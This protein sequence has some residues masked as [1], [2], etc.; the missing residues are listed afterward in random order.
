MTSD[1]NAILAAMRCISEGK[2]D[3]AR[4]LCRQVLEKNPLSAPG[5]HTLGLVAYMAR[6]Y[7]TAIEHITRAT[8]IDG[9][10]PQY[11]SNLG[12][13][14]R[15]AGRSKDALETFDK[16]L[17]AMPEFLK[18]HLGAGNALRDLGRHQEA[19]AK[20]RLALAIDPGFAEAYHYLGLALAEQERFEEALP[21][22]RKAVAIRPGYG[23]AQLTL[24]NTL[25]RTGHTEEALG[26]YRQILERDPGN[27]AVHNNIGNLLKS[28][29]RIEE[30]I[31]HY[32]QALELDPD[33]APAYYNL[34][35][36]QVGSAEEELSRMEA[37]LEDRHLA[38]ER[39]VNLHFALGKILDDL[40]RY[41]EAFPHFRTGNELDGRGRPFNA[42][43]HGLAINR[44]IGVFSRRFITARRGFGS[45]SE[46]P[47]LI[48]GM[49]RSGTSL[50]EQILASHPRVFGAGELD[51]IGRIVAALPKALG[52]LAGYPDCATLLDAAAACRFGEE[53]VSRLRVVGGDA[54]RV[55]DKM[56]GNFLNLGFVALLLPNARIIHCRRQ[57]LDVCLSCYFQ[58]FTSVM[59][60]TWNLS[61]LGRYYRDYERLMAHWRKV[62]PLSMLE[63]DYEE[64]IDNQE[65]TSRRIVD[66]VGLEWDDACLEFHKTDRPVKTASSWQVRQ[67]IY[68]SSVARWRNYEHFLGPLREAL[69][70]VLSESGSEAEAEEG[71][72][73]APARKRPTARKK[74]A[75]RKTASG[76]P[77]R[78]KPTLEPDHT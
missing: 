49:P 47:V 78:R 24:A 67:P 58:H 57:P 73:K 65:E 75:A 7:A 10:N 35:R 11:L 16:A 45:E 8:Q 38:G 52:D 14:L 37:L 50:I 30:S 28:L 15:R 27:S 17:I 76:N 69:G 9:E 31:L 21:L 53:Y 1:D 72:K 33:H 22:L 32:R 61:D 23:E 64:L 6:D 56:P 59:P 19:V 51:A 3:E 18:A 40:G 66:F 60:F 12:E 54:L 71:G 41:D 25:D 5:Q 4:R 74:A 39:R 26:T 13:A 63:I 29:G 48:V 44:L 20:F 55:T 68:A 36:A 70:D 34:S 46:L 2:L 42:G 77:R 43:D 62:L